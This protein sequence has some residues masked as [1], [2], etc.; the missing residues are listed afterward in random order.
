MMHFK[1]L[2]SIINL[3]IALS[4]AL[5]VQLSDPCVLIF[6]KVENYIDLAEDIG[7]MLHTENKLCIHVFTFNFIK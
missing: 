3:K 6:K 7:T 4:A 1:L 5:L 2:F